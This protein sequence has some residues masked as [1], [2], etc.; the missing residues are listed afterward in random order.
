MVLLLLAAVVGVVVS[1]A[2]W[3]FLELIYQIQNGVFDELP[4]QLGYENGAPLWWSLPVLGLAGLVVA[5]A[6][7]YPAVGATSPPRA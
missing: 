4:G 5:F 1:V 6:I 2:A 7:G 3:G